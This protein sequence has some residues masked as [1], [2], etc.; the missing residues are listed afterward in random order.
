[1][2]LRL[3]R[4]VLGAPRPSVRWRF[5]PLPRYQRTIVMQH[6][7]ITNGVEIEITYLDAD[8]NVAPVQGAVQWAASNPAKLSIFP[9]NASA[10]KIHVQGEG[11]VTDEVIQ[12]RSKAD[13][14]LGDGVELI[15]DF[16]EILIV[17]GR[18]T[19]STI[20]FGGLVPRLPAA[21]V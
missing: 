5:F 6:L 3:L 7:P 4:A 2:L 17:A 16:V 14:D 19:H 13:A 11:P 21:P 1:M 9:L 10:T 8:G 20:K 15:E 12:L 18:A